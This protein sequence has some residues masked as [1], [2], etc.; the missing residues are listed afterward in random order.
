MIKAFYIELKKLK[1]RKLFL[2]LIGFLTMLFFWVAVTTN[3]DD[4]YVIANGYYSELYQLP[5]MNTILLPVFIAVIAS[6]IW[7]TEHKGNTFK[8]LY[9]LQ[10]RSSIYFAKSMLG[11]LFM[12]LISIGEFIIILLISNLY[13]F[14]QALPVKHMIIFCITTFLTN[15]LLY[16]IQEILS[17]LFENQM[18]A[19]SIGLIGSFL[20]LFGCFFARSAQQYIIWSYYSVLQTIG[21]NWDEVTREISYFEASLSLS[22]I[23]ILCILLVILIPTGN[24]LFAKHE[25]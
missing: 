13:G 10:Q 25:V 18:V 15:A 24:L 22:H 11:V 8:L 20:G 17:C 12:L 23:L 19:L 21:M 4:A 5:I 7:D 3:A 14:T 9:T 1:H 6:R 2:L 16:F